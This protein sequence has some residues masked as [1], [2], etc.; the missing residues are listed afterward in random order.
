MKVGIYHNN[1]LMTI[2]DEGRQS[3]SVITVVCGAVGALILMLILILSVIITLKCASKCY[4]ESV[5]KSGDSG[6]LIDTQSVLF[7]EHCAICCIRDTI[8]NI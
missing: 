1:I 3:V 2:V 8:R 5:N 4:S 7:D 6:E